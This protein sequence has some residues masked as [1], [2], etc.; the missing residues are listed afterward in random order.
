MKTLFTRKTVVSFCLLLMT[1]LPWSCVDHVDPTAVKVICKCRIL[2]VT[3]P[4]DLYDIDSMYCPTPSHTCE[5]GG[6]QYRGT[7]VKFECN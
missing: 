3:G 7:I 6:L 5:C 1:G 2:D 4:Q